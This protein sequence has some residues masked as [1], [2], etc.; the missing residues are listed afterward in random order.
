MLDAQMRYLINP[1]LNK[2]AIGLVRLG[3]SAN[4]ITVSGFLIGL[5][6]VPL[7]AFHHYEWALGIIL[8]NRVMDGLDGAVARQVGITD[9]GGYLDIVLDFIFY[10]AIIFGFALANPEQAVYSAFLIFS[11]IG[12]GSSFLAFAI[13]AAKHGITTEIRGARSIYYLG[14][15]TEGTETIVLFVL[16]CLMPAWFAVLATVF[17]VMCWITT[18]TRIYF[19]FEHLGRIKS[20]RS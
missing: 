9:I 12:T 20:N 3:V 7:I 1:V 14:G 19:A 18:L 16:L 11:F 6:A 5:C 15:L 13:F 17:G 2:A 8:G 10:S 4:T